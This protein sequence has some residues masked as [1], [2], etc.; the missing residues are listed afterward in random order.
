MLIP[1]EHHICYIFVC[2]LLARGPDCTFSCFRVYVLWNLYSNI[3]WNLFIIFIYVWLYVYLYMFMF[4]YICF[5]I[6]VCNL[7]VRGPDCVRSYV[8]EFIQ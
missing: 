4:F 2:N 8:V 3:Y 7:L 1:L 5:I 6:F